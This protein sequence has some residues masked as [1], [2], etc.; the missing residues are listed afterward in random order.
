MCVD[1]FC[2]ACHAMEDSS[3]ERGVE[4]LIGERFGKEAANYTAGRRGYGEALYTYLRQKM[5]SDVTI[6]DVG[7][8]TGIATRELYEHGF[9]AIQGCDIDPLMILEADRRSKQLNLPIPYKCA[10]VVD[11]ST[12]FPDE[13]FDVIT[14]FTCFHWFCNQESIEVIFRKLNPYGAFVVV[15]VARA[16]LDEAIL[17]EFWAIIE[18]V[19]G[20]PVLDPRHAY[21]PEEALKN[22]GC[23]V[24]VHTWTHDEYYTFEEVMAKLQTFSGWCALTS[25]EKQRGLPLLEKFVSSRAE[26][27]MHRMVEVTCLVAALPIYTIR[28]ESFNASHSREEKQKI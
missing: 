24:E 10:A 17:K 15:S 7:C 16:N 1:F 8:G 27:L 6:L 18:Q 4:A 11:L 2:I 25:E 21:N 22:Y 3:A 5:R 12:V 9:H 23:S 20:K 28:V 19:S 26:I 13:Q 14:A